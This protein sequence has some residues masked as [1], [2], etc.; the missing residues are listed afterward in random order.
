MKNLLIGAALACAMSAPAFA[1]SVDEFSFGGGDFANAIPSS[2]NIGVFDE[3]Y[4]DIYG[5][6]DDTCISGICNNGPDGQDSFVF[7]VSNGFQLDELSIS[8]EGFGSAQDV[9]YSVYMT[10]LYG[11]GTYIFETYDLNSGGM[12]VTSPLD[13]GSYEISVYGQSASTDGYYQAYW[14]IYGTVSEVAQ[15]PVPLPAGLPLVLSALGGLGLVSRRK[16][17]SA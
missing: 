13:A 4:N 16:R 3:G 6:L 14:G 5:M 1:L 11:G 15:A 12:F 17:K 10:D 7:T 9:T 8:A 2:D